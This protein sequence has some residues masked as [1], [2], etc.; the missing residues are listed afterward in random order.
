[1]RIIIGDEPEVDFYPF[2]G[3]D[4][5]TNRYGR[6]T[7]AEWI[8]HS[9]SYISM[10]DGQ[11]QESADGKH[12]LLVS[13]SMVYYEDNYGGKPIVID[14][15]ASIDYNTP[16]SRWEYLPNIQVSES[17]FGITEFHNMIYTLKQTGQ[18]DRRELGRFLPHKVV[19]TTYT[20]TSYMNPKHIEGSTSLQ[21]TIGI[22]AVEDA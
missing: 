4:I 7:N 19:G 13:S 21:F 16:N 1:M 9:A 2:T 22:E 3:N 5:N 14:L 15:G 12:L 11:I 8:Y 17:Y 18:L 10:I 6:Y 20:I